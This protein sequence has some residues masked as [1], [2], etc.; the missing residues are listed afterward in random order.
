MVRLAFRDLQCNIRTFYIQWFIE[1]HIIYK[2]HAEAFN[3][4]RKNLL[5]DVF[6]LQCFSL[7][8]G[9]GEWIRITYISITISWLSTYPLMLQ[10][11]K[12]TS[13]VLW[14]PWECDTK[15][16]ATKRWN[17]DFRDCVGV[18]TVWW[19]NWSTSFQQKKLF[20][21]KR[22]LIIFH[23]ERGRKG[24]WNIWSGIDGAIISDARQVTH[25]Y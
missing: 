6:I 11:V 12:V 2:P 1:F 19:K 5:K 15:P 9:D 3:W 17:T 4:A 7:F 22:N 16:L 24:D 18:F 8:G 13:I 23:I 21:I 14:D 25:P 10:M 20:C